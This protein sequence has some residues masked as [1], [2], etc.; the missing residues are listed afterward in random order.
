MRLT[1]FL[2]VTLAVLAAACSDSASAPESSRTQ[3]FITDSPFPYD[4][5]ARV[6]IHI[7][8]IDA[9]A[10][11]DTTGLDP[12]VWVPV[13]EPR[14]TVNLL[15]LTAGTKSLL[16]EAD[17]AAGQYQ[18]LRVVINTALSSITMK[19]GS[20]A[21]VQWPMQGELTLY[22]YVEDPL[23]VEPAGARIVLDF[24]VG[25][26]FLPQGANGFVFLPWIRAV[27]EAATGALAGTVWGGGSIEGDGGGP[28]PN[29]TI[30]ML[31]GNFQLSPSTWWVAATGRTG[32]DGAYRIGY[33]GEATYIVRVEGTVGGARSCL[34]F[35]GIA[36]QRGGAATLNAA[37]PNGPLA[38]FSSDSDGTDTS[39]TTPGPI[40]AIAI[41]P[42]LQTAHVGD[43]L[44]VWAS[45][46]DANGSW[47]TGQ[48]AW[49]LSDSTLA[50]I[51]GQ[52]GQWLL[53][54]SLKAGSLT[55][56]AAANGKNGSG[57]IIIQP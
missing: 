25:R 2:G 44:G 22:A 19:D 24:D 27:N 39:G 3:V 43:S 28:V 20:P 40:A 52:G 12:A 45:L 4:A 11:L 8:R 49:T 34:V 42:A 14:R 51:D 26:S 50:R 33:L 5:V 1:R 32:A 48:V 9:S 29:A 16:G 53:L 54:R 46:T 23:A 55:V 6:D 21:A 38:C 36:V 37:L 56:T 57:T 35:S 17:L 13:V 47:T 30:T 10:T 7:V 18:A 31:R 41:S 15:E